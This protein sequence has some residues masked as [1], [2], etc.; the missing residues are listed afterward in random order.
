MSM[1]LE[2]PL[3]RAGA[4]S[5]FERLGQ[6]GRN[7]AGTLLKSANISTSGRRWEDQ[8]VP[9]RLVMELLEG[10]AARHDLPF[11]GLH[12]SELQDI[13]VL[14]ALGVAINNAR[15]LRESFQVIERHVHFHSPAIEV[16]LENATSLYDFLSFDIA[17]AKIPSSI[18]TFELSLALTHRTASSLVRGVYSPQEVW[19]MHQPIAAVSEYRRIFGTTPKFMMPR[20]GLLISRQNLALPVIGRSETLMDLAEY[21]LD[22]HPAP[23]SSLVSKETRRLVS[24]LIRTDKCTQSKIATLMRI[25][26]RTLQRRLNDENTTFDS[27]L[28]DV[29]RDLAK[30]YLATTMLSISKVSELL[31]F[32]ET[33][34]FSRACKRWFGVS[35][36]IVRQAECEG[37]S[38]RKRTS[39]G[40]PYDLSRTDAVD[41]SCSTSVWP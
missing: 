32:A 5:G 24:H 39:G 7:R 29:Q 13:N 21:Y 25:S 1:C 12:L 31:H 16:R 3:L 11:L 18:Q 36:K 27:I 20:T 10:V 34:A 15:T 4:V 33:S 8:Y 22:S 23:S 14:G 40:S 28:D 26:V 9:C 2:S 17:M 30:T 37:Q 38:S 6:L 41:V 19:F 35:P